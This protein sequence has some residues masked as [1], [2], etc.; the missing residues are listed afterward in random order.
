VA[1]PD[2]LAPLVHEFRADP[3]VRWEIAD[4]LSRIGDASILDDVVEFARDPDSGRARIPLADY[5]GRIRDPKSVAAVGVLLDDED[6]GPNAL[7]AAGKLGAQEL[8][9][10]VERYLRHDKAW[11]RREAVKA[12]ARIDRKAEK[13]RR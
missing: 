4:A 8:R 11:G 9:P 1:K 13:G 3:R 6:V 2:A 7:A 10:Q 5:L 12:L